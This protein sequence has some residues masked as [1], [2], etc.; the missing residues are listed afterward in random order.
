M[1]K[2]GEN[3][4][5]TGVYQARGSQQN[6]DRVYLKYEH[7]SSLAALDLLLA[8]IVELGRSRTSNVILPI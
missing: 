6:I 2:H 3:H 7:K 4:T 5:A 8:Q 1:G